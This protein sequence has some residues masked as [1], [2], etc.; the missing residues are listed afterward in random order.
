MV[1]IL[2]DCNCSDFLS[3]K[4]CFARIKPEKGIVHTRFLRN[5]QTIEQS[6]ICFILR[7]IQV[8]LSFDL[9]ITNKKEG[10][11]I[12]TKNG[13]IEGT[14]LIRRRKVVKL[15]LQ[16]GF[17][18]G[19]QERGVLG[20]TFEKTNNKIAPLVL[21]QQVDGQPPLPGR[22]LQP[23]QEQWNEFKCDARDNITSTGSS[24]PASSSASHVS[25]VFYQRLIQK[26]KELTSC[27]R[28]FQGWNH[29][30]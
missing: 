9:Q 21:Q 29:L 13:K 14:N 22:C 5:R 16:P 17:S 26:K 6:Y 4:Y 8:H 12:K 2:L 10:G 15:H 19:H 23:V 7:N 20:K 1:C 24:I 30:R 25:S 11:V 28:I 3:S 27:R 18:S